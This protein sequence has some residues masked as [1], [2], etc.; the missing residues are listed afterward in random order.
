MSYGIFQD[1][2]MGLCIFRILSPHLFPSPFYISKYL[3]SEQFSYT[4][5]HMLTHTCVYVP[6]CVYNK[7]M[8]L[9]NNI[10][11]FWLICLQRLSS[12]DPGVPVKTKGLRTGRADGESSSQSKLEGQKRLMSISETIRQRELFL[13]FYSLQAFS[14]SVRPTH[15]GKGNLLFSA[16]KFKC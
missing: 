15:I 5:I 7:Y 1:S 13:Y 3:H 10:V 2:V 16:D 8:T 9:F 14:D 12:S 4:H 6:V 11:N